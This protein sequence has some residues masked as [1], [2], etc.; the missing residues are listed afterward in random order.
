MEPK[1]SLFPLELL[2]PTTRDVARTVRDGGAGALVDAERRADHARY[3][4]V[5]CRS[6]LNAVEGMPFRWTLNPYRGCT[7]ACHYCFARRYHA[8]FELGAGDEFATV[9]LV[10]QNL[11]GVLTR[12]LARPSW[13]RDL[14][15][16]GTA[17][18]PYQPIEGHYALTRGALEAFAHAATPVG[19]VTKGPLVVRD[20]DVL[21]EVSARASC[22]VYVSVPSVDEDAWRRLE[23]GTAS[24]LQRLRAV[25]TLAEAG[26]HAG[27]LMAPLVPG[28]TT[29]PKIVA[30]T[31]A[32]I[33]D[34]GAKFVGAN[35]LFLEGGTRS[36]F[37]AF[38]EREY[39]HLCERYGSLYAGGKRPDRAYA[40]EVRSMV[41]GL[42]QRAG[43][44]GSDYEERAAAARADATRRAEESTEPQQAFR[45]E[46]ET[47]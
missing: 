34:H 43:L 28:I 41:R 9:I 2:R 11:V 15:A 7:H 31:V 5:H 18:D 33:A 25:R 36:H 12:E 20:I 3:Q 39:P 4:E 35:I 38:L 29:H 32:A 40:A 45:W 24:P 47:G 42:Q 10:K 17:T 1:A 13:Q 46:E 26:I 27:V 22:S 16:V 14:V 30:R 37:L 8:Q 44:T 21:R 19:I 6:A 23:P